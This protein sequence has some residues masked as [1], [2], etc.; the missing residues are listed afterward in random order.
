MTEFVIVLIG[1]PGVGKSTVANFLLDGYDSNKCMASK[2]TG[3]SLTQDVQCETGRTF[4]EKN[5]KKIKVFD[6]PGLVDPS[7]PIDE[8]VEK[9]K[10]GITTEQNIDMVLM[11]LKATDYRFSF[12]D[13]A[14]AQAMQTFLEGLKPLNT[15]LCFTHCDVMKETI[16]DKFFTQKMKSITK[17]TKLKINEDNR[18]KFD[19]TKESLED[20]VA[21]FV[22]GQIYIAENMEDRIEELYEELPKVIKIVDQYQNTNYQYICSLVIPWYLNDDHTKDTSGDVDRPDNHEENKSE[23][24]EPGKKTIKKKDKRKKSKTPKKKTSK[25]YKPTEHENKKKD[26]NE[27]DKRTK[28][29]KE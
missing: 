16:D 8:W 27:F 28:A 9:V 2:Y 29:Y 1:G 11:V 18:I 20:F 14:S 10:Y 23:E 7:M 5:G 15:F 22:K 24:D 12:A 25:Y 4:G 19:L 17:Y 6:T 3:S 21:N 13:I 26:S